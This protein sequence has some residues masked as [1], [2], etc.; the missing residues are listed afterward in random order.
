MRFVYFKTVHRFDETEIIHF[1][2]S[3]N[4]KS[5]E[6]FKNINSDALIE[7]I[8]KLNGVDYYSY[9]TLDEENKKELLLEVEEILK[10][11]KNGN[12]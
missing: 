12:R 9:E 3:K 11:F 2:K 10:D 1:L 6:D 5:I 8:L 4:I 7:Q